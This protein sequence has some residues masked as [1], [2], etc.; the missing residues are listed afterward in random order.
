M[1]KFQIWENTSLKDATGDYTCGGLL[2][3]E[4]E[5]VQ[6]ATL[7]GG[8]YYLIPGLSLDATDS[9]T[10]A[11]AGDSIYDESDLREFLTEQGVKFDSIDIASD[12]ET[13]RSIVCY[14]TQERYFS[15]LADFYAEPTYQWWDGSNWKIEY[16]GDEITVTEV[17]V[18]DDTCQNLDEWD[19]S[20]WKTGGTNFYH[21][22]VFRVLELD[23]EKVE[24][25]YLLREYDQ[26]ESNHDTARIL[27]ADELA[28]RMTEVS[29]NTPEICYNCKCYGDEKS[30]CCG[31]GNEKP[32]PCDP[33][34]TCS[35]FTEVSDTLGKS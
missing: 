6:S 11:L 22:D 14:D 18:E 31:V 4:E 30:G 26:Y 25:M 16:C 34:D 28:K 13:I 19:G 3:P 20:N 8:T 10:K 1:K 24:N 27:T 17:T 15:D 32:E 12:F 29:N 2:V 9:L 7:H 5:I 21:E 23:G 35:Q 33:L